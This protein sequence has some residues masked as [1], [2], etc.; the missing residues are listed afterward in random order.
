MRVPCT[1]AWQQSPRSFFHFVVLQPIS[2]YMVLFKWIYTLYGMLSGCIGQRFFKET[3]S[4]GYVEDICVRF[5]MG[6]GSWGYRSWGIPQSA[7][8]EWKTQ[9]SWWYNSV[10]DWKLMNQGSQWCNSIWSQRL[11]NQGAT[12]LCP[13]PRDSKPKNQ[14]VHYARTE[15]G[16]PTLRRKR[17]GICSPLPCCSILA[18]NGLGDAHPH[19]WQ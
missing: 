19:W 6:V 10:Q 3:K 5:I 18:F 4:T 17:E 15:D 11:K 9:E 16:H 8:N 1:A 7:T 2:V 12:G 13:N 14:E